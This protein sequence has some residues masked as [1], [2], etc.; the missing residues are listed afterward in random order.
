M[1]MENYEVL[2]EIGEGSF[3]KVCLIR[4]KQNKKT[5]VWKKINYG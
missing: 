1:K 3:G 2:K 4:H 5:M